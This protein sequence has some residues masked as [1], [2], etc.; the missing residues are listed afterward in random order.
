MTMATSWKAGDTAIT[1]PV[2][3]RDEGDAISVTLLA[4]VVIE[5][6]IRGWIVTD[7]DGDQ[8]FV[9]IEDLFVRH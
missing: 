3:A 7:Q 5:G 2:F 4:Q 9:D 8:S 6:E 1:M